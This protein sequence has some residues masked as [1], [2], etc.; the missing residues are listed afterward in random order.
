MTG[1]RTPPCYGSTGTKPQPQGPAD[2]LVTV[3]EGRVGVRWKRL[4]V[5]SLSS[6]FLP[7]P[8][9]A[10]IPGHTGPN[11]AGA[12][13]ASGAALT[14]PEAP[15]APPYLQDC[16]KGGGQPPVLPK[17]AGRVRA[18]GGAPAV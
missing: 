18:G 1:A 11:Y 9:N 6:L 12:L 17:R 10:C 4:T 13:E 15:A 3:G 2:S 5:P 16:R 14:R 8:P 7:M